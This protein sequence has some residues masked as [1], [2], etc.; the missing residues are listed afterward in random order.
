MTRRRASGQP[1]ASPKAAPGF[2]LCFTGKSTAQ[3][4]SAALFS[5][6]PTLLAALRLPSSSGIAIIER[7]ALTLHGAR[8]EAVVSLRASSLI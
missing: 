8:P 4:R 6:A 1:R 2:R 7:D 3:Q 5:W